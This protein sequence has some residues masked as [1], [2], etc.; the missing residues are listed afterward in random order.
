MMPLSFRVSE[1]EIKAFHNT[2]RHRGSRLCTEQKGNKNQLVCPYHQWTYELTGK[3]KY[4]KDMEREDHFD[5][6][7]NG[8]HEIHCE[9]VSGNVYLSFAETAPDFYRVRNVP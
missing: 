3:L 8:L 6:N 5:L 7:Q 4:A 1:S 2:C 9:V